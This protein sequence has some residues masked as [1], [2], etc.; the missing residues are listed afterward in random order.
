MI[1]S[2]LTEATVARYKDHPAVVMWHINNELG[3]H[4]AYDYSDGAAAAFRD[5][6]RAR[7]AGAAPG[8]EK[9][10]W[11]ERSV[12]TPN[13][14]PIVTDVVRPVLLHYPADRGKA[15]D[16]PAISEEEHEVVLHEEEVV[17]EKRAVPKERVR[18][19]KDVETEE[20]EVSETVRSER[21]DVDD[22]RR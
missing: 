8:S 20:R 5:W 7:Y 19:E 18:L 21:I 6:L 9:W 13:G 4:V 14:L 22:N 17:T 11:S 1:A 10:D 2:A 12:T 15:V 16:G 3:C